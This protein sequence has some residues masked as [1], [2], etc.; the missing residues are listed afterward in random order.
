MAI[1]FV[2]L[3]LT[4]IYLANIIIRLF[5]LTWA[6]FRRSTWDLYAVFA[7]AGTLVT[8]FLVLVQIDNT[9]FNRIQKLFLVAIALLLIPRNNQLDQLFKTAAASLPLIVNLLATWFVLFLVFAI[10][11][12]QAFSLTR[13][14][15]NET[16][17]LNLRDVPK[18]MILLFR[19]S[20]G[21]GWN[22]IMEDYA[23]VRPPFCVEGSIF[24][25]DCGSANWARF[26]FIAWNILSM[27]L[28]AN[29]FISLIYESFSYVYQHSSGLSIISREEIRR[30]KEAWAVVDPDGTGYINKDALPKLLRELSGVFEMRIYDG[31]YTVKRLTDDCAKDNRTSAFSTVS[32]AT[33]SRE[34]DLKK[35]NARLVSLPVPEIRRRRARLRQ[36]YEEVLVSSERE[37]GIE[38]NTFLM[39]L[40]HYKVINDNKSLRLNEFLKRRTRLQRVDEAVRRQIVIGFFDT[41]FWRRYLRLHQ[42]RQRAGRMQTVP[43][44][45]V[46]EIYVEDPDSATGPAHSRDVSVDDGP[47][48]L[49]PGSSPRSSGLATPPNNRN[50]IQISPPISPPGRLTPQL[51]GSDRQVTHSV[52]PPSGG[53]WAARRPSFDVP[54]LELTAADD[55]GPNGGYPGDGAVSP[56]SAAARSRANSSVSVQG[57]I[58]ALDSSAWGES[59]RRSFST[60]RPSVA[61]SRAGTLGA[62]SSSARDHALREEDGDDVGDR[63]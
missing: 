57:V 26:L 49:T 54:H 5:G 27:Y 28:F 47:G 46:P 15:T 7:V 31:D 18:A 50:S 55:D 42:E 41:V 10:A 35:L 59:L 16:D 53:A 8:T 32:V 11:L 63:V 9:V 30:F 61:R 13:F 17:N 21:E 39:I 45:M 19:S 56:V 20:V 33:P 25:S 23:N 22:Q 43:Q 40:A 3:L 12:T 14:G 34:I 52:S 51:T 48:A 37:R 29:L 60:R 62:G 36:F 24:D 2:F 38:F 4:L 1:D 44:L 58:D 6:R